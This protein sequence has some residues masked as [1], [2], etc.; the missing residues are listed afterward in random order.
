MDH[1]DSWYF[2]LFNLEDLLEKKASLSWTCLSAST[3][4]TKR[5]EYWAPYPRWLALGSAEEV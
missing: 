5:K 1:M 4:N 2:L 3:H